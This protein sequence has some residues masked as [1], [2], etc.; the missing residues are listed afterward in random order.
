MHT[1][2]RDG[3]INTSLDKTSQEIN[4][5]NKQFD[6]LHQ[7]FIETDKNLST[8]IFSLNNEISQITENYFSISQKI[9]AL[10][11][12]QLSRTRTIVPTSYPKA[13]IKEEPH[14]NNNN[15]IVTEAQEA[16]HRNT[17]QMENELKSYRFKMEL[18]MKFMK[19][20]LLKTIK[21][22]IQPLEAKMEKAQN[23][24][25]SAN[26]ELKDKL[27]WFPIKVSEISGM[28]PYDA[29]LFTIEARLRAEENSR[30]QALNNVEKSLETIRKCSLS[31][32]FYKS[33]ERRATPD[34]KTSFDGLKTV[35]EIEE[36]RPSGVM[37]GVV[38]D[39]FDGKRGRRNIHKSSDF[40][41][42]LHSL[43][44]RKIV[45]RKSFKK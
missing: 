3:Q 32:I 18:E 14:N 17:L 6:F 21:D 11:R 25:E 26:S 45:R 34:I 33:P 5:L 1:I 13:P 15:N 40:N 8:S 36:I 28:S 39:S 4:T 41:K 16:L 7:N 30:I 35:S 42:D 29:R 43:T 2:Q 23:S 9:E 12:N 27:S 10:E 44:L 37:E 31:P 19:N 24:L 20:E 22:H 38:Y